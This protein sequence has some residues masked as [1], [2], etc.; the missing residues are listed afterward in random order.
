MSS[1]LATKP[2]KKKKERSENQ[3][4]H[5][6]LRGRVLCDVWRAFQY[7]GKNELHHVDAVRASFYGGDYLADLRP[8]QIV[9]NRMERPAMIH[10]NPTPANIALQGKKITTS[11]PMSFDFTGEAFKPDYVVKCSYGNDSIA[12][13]QFLHEYD[14]KHTLGRVAVIYND[15]GFAARWW[16]ARV[17][18]GEKLA[19]S[20]GF[21]P[22]QTMSIG[23]MEL[24]IR[25]N[26][27]P[28]SQMRF[29]T[30]ELKIAPTQAWLSIH[31][32]DGL[33]ETIC[34]VRREESQERKNWPEFVSSERTSEGRAQW[35]PL[36]YHDESMR[37]ELITRA[38]WKVL[39]SRSRECKCVLANAGEIKTWGEDDIQ[40]IE[41]M[42]R[43]LRELRERKGQTG[44][45][46]YIFKPHR[47]KGNPEGIRAVVQWA[48]S[49]KKKEKATSGCDSGYCTG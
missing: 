10:L 7:R 19:R 44:P 5:R 41:N 33:A 39:P 32:P 43:E 25:R 49:V 4:H 14:Q 45:N 13:L 30:Y 28:D 18:N 23:M 1:L 31:D 9:D 36:V 8:L 29:C 12:L 35:S 37:N 22:F 15:T 34:G 16:P 6:G 47:M 48:K 2:P 27:W 46:Q 3:N 11:V 21:T 24:I 42:E 40:D 38:G 20:F 17:I 26:T